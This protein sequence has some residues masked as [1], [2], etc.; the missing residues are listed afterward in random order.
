MATSFCSLGSSVSSSHPSFCRLKS[1][2]SSEENSESTVCWMVAFDPVLCCSRSLTREPRSCKSSSA[3]QTV[4]TQP[5]KKQ[6]AQGAGTHG[7]CKVP[8]VALPLAGVGRL[9]GQ[10]VVVA[11]PTGGNQAAEGI[12]L[13]AEGLG[14]LGD[15]LGGAV[16]LV[17]GVPEVCVGDDV[18]RGEVGQ[19]G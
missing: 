12:L 1:S 16:K 18:G 6:R 13:L 17:D 19:A 10:A 15:G 5:S 2:L 9:E 8:P 14:V 3:W 4:S 7:G 11:L